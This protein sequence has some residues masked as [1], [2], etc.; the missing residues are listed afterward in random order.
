M[1]SLVLDFLKDEKSGL[2]FSESSSSKKDGAARLRDIGVLCLS[3]D[4]MSEK[5]AVAV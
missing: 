1:P 5:T 4:V 3:G 2:M